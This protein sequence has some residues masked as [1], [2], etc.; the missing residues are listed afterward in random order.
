[1]HSRSVDVRQCRID[2]ACMW[3]GGDSAGAPGARRA[4]LDSDAPRSLNDMICVG[5]HTGPLCELCEEGLS[6]GSGNTCNV[7]TDKPGVFL[8]LSLIGQIAIPFAVL[9]AVVSIIR[10]VFNLP[11]TLED[12]DDDDEDDGKKKKKKKKEED[13]DDDGEEPGCLEAFQQTPFARRVR[14]V[15]M[16][17]LR[18]VYRFLR[19]MRHRAKNAGAGMRRRAS[20]MAAATRK[21]STKLNSTMAD[22]V[23]VTVNA[24]HQPRADEGRG[25]G[26]G[27]TAGSGVASPQGAVTVAGSAGPVEAAPEKEPIKWGPKIKVIIS[28]FQLSSIV[29]R[30]FGVLRVC[31]VPPVDCHDVR[32][33][34]GAPQVS[35]Y[36]VPFPPEVT[37]IS[38]F[39]EIF[40]VS[41][42]TFIQLSCRADGVDEFGRLIIMSA[43]P[44]L[45][46]AIFFLLS[47]VMSLKV[48][49]C[50]FAAR[51]VSLGDAV[52]CVR[53]QVPERYL[54]NSIMSAIF[55]SAKR[56]RALQLKFFNLALFVSYLCLPSVASIVATSF[57]CIDFDDGSSFLDA[58]FRVNCHSPRYKAMGAW[59]GRCLGRCHRRCPDP[60]IFACLCVPAV[61]YAVAM[62]LMFPI[63]IPCFYAFVLWKYR[64]VIYPQNMGR[65]VTM[66]RCADV[67]TPD[68]AELMAS[69]VTPVAKVD[70]G[71]SRCMYCGFALQSQV[72]VLMS[73][74][75]LGSWLRRCSG[76]DGRDASHVRSEVAE[77]SAD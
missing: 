16:R 29:V 72:T 12:D 9:Y 10:G 18:R 46:M 8:K 6:R 48:C 71:E 42:F 1:M 45:L 19:R 39:F 44:A 51:V 70:S 62:L 50:T 37:K 41:L 11:L 21:K 32:G 25:G 58:D 60:A 76:G 74:L 35:E 38:G 28:F 7:C 5:N 55:A 68:L 27:G 67:P 4:L 14:E 30:A 34:R 36:S 65:C 2:N 69:P 49:C 3:R 56:C 73:L 66:Q 24:A 15:Y 17:Q 31:A 52:A 53:L 54:S 77:V 23:V 33:V 57:R 13:D 59:R 22:G 26:G 64:R 20:N 40:N 47:W 75:A 63:G 61:A 43:V